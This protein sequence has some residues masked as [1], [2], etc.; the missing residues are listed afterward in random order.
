MFC[1]FKASG[2]FWEPFLREK[3]LRTNF[4]PLFCYYFKVNEKIYYYVDIVECW[5][6]LLTEKIF[7]NIIKWFLCGKMRSFSLDKKEFK[8]WVYATKINHIFISAI[9]TE[10][11]RKYLRLWIVFVE[12]DTIFGMMVELIPEPNEMRISQGMCM[13]AGKLLFGRITAKEKKR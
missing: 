2:L 4:F 6:Y 5:W 3:K 13:D 11:Q 7:I 1:K 10:I 8:R 9:L 12:Q